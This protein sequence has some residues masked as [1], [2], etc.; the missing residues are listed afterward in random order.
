M[1]NDIFAY[2]ERNRTLKASTVLLLLPVLNNPRKFTF[3][4]SKLL[5]DI[6]IRQKFSFELF[7]AAEFVSCFSCIRHRQKI[8]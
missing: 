7:L 6:V 1:V 2:Y 3:G 8:R 4:S 5:R